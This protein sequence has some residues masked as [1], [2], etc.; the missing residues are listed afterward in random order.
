MEE[1]R[2]HRQS[3]IQ[4]KAGRTTGEPARS[5]R[6]PFRRR[7]PLQDQIALSG[8]PAR[9]LRG[10]H[11]HHRDCDRRGQARPQ[12]NLRHRAVAPEGFERVLTVKFGHRTGSRGRLQRLIERT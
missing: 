10:R 6:R 3:A 11:D 8:L 12:R 2:A 9:L 5:Q 1:A 7:E 4:E